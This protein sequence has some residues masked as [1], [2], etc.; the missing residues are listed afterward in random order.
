MLAPIN[1]LIGRIEVTTNRGRVLLS[2]VPSRLI[3]RDFLR[4]WSTSKITSSIFT[5]ITGS[6]LEFPEFFA[7]E[8][9]YMFQRMLDEPKMRTNRRAIKR[10]IELL[11]TETWL[12]RL[13]QQHP[14]ILNYKKLDELNVTLMESQQELL[15]RYDE[16]VPKFGL[17]G[18][19]QADPAGTGKTISAVALK[20]TLEADQ[21]F[22]VCP[23][24]AVRE[25]WVATLQARLRKP[26]TIWTSQDGTPFN[27][28]ADW[29]I[30]HYEYLPKLIADQNKIRC[31]KPFVVLDECHNLNEQSQRTG[32]FY[33][34]VRG[35]LGC[36]HV[37]WMSGTP[38]KALGREAAPFLRCIDPCFTKDVEARF[39][40]MFGKTASR[41]NDVL[42]HR[43]GYLTHRTDKLSVVDNQV[44]EEKILVQVPKADQ[45]T[46]PAVQEQIR[47]F[48]TER[49]AYYHQNRKVYEETYQHGLRLWERQLRTADQQREYAVYEQYVQAIQAVSRYDGVT[50]EIIFCNNY[51]RKHIAPTLPKGI[52]KD[53]LSACSVVKYVALK[54][55]GEALGRILTR[56][57]IECFQA[58][59]PHIGL[60]DLIDNAEGK[61]ILF[62]SFVE[63]VDS[64]YNY[65]KAEG[66]QPLRVYGETKSEFDSIMQ[67]W[68][69]NPDANPLIATY[70][71]LSTAVP[72]V[73]ANEM[74]LL[75][76]PYRD[77]ERTQA[78][79]RI[80]RKDQK[81]NVTIWSA[82]LD[83]GETPN[84]STR[85]ADILQWSREQVDEIMGS[86]GVP[87]VTVESLVDDYFVPH[88]GL[89]GYLEKEAARTERPMAKGNFFF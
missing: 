29:I 66:Y 5:K 10:C 8:V 73:E 13:E 32:N 59:V 79:A 49:L 72:L 40:G 53:W 74:V 45:W 56:A 47:Q 75:N 43:L 9:R 42:A 18:Y 57:R 41:A 2:G 20:S 80:D 35:Y 28:K 64:A 14:S 12:V 25:V 52:A 17:T 62:T 22:V 84:L 31:R 38:I 61:M 68:R 86:P 4:I 78:T 23:G 81:L 34:F 36:E 55:R 15:R 63:V 82:I 30:V 83:T 54:V 16:E 89:Q 67:A 19:L 46:L 1:R 58:L 24:Q 11:G 85:T 44:K 3:Q 21:G 71:S 65:L 51:E 88:T 39:L 70:K 87:T 27:P 37:L 33:D 69:N 6:S 50:E 60:P 77:Y 76:E 26:V 7:L 48:C